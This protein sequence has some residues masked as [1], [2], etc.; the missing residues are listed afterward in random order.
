[1][2]LRFIGLLLTFFSLTCGA[3]TNIF[4]LIQPKSLVSISSVD[5]SGKFT[6]VKGQVTISKD[7]LLVQGFD[8]IIDVNTLDLEIPGMTKHAKSADFF[9]VTNFPSITFFGDS[10]QSL[11]GK[12]TV[13]GT[14]KAKG[15]ERPMAIPFTVTLDNK[16]ITVE[17][18]FTINLSDFSIG[19]KEEVSDEVLIKATLLGKKSK[20]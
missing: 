15:V 13:F 2:R 18:L 9:D 4:F 11:G 19:L 10:V 12:G 6:S 8:L 5:F 16:L 17:T 20:D 3:Q 7:S 14:M 1:M